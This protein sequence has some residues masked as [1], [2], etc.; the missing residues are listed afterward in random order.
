MVFTLS[1][2]ELHIETVCAILISKA[3]SSSPFF[4]SCSDK[5][6]RECTFIWEA[7]VLILCRA[8]NTLTY[9]STKERRLRHPAR[10]VL[11]LTPVYQI[12]ERQAA[13]LRMCFLLLDSMYFYLGTLLIS[14]Y[15]QNSRQAL[16]RVVEWVL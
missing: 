14:L 9:G 15:R 4:P 3:L 7:A 12:I 13:F 10:L 8:R 11:L 2:S 1:N 16:L 6:L 5:K